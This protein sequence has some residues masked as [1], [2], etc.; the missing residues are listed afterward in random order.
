[1]AYKEVP[2]VEITELIRQW[3]AHRGIREITRSTGMARNTI[4]RYLLAAERFGLARDGPEPTESQLLAL[5][6]LNS[7]SPRHVVTP[8]AE[9]LEP[10]ADQIQQWLQQNKL[11]LT[12]VQEL[13]LQGALNNSRYAAA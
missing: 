10:W 2:R 13:L 1:M 9:I 7:A 4:R 3:P 6:Q 5:V 12:R 8:T 11:K